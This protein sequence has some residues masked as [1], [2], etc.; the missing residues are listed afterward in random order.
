M[1]YHQLT[2][3]NGLD[4]Y[5][6]SSA[7]QKCIR[8]G[9]E[10]EAMQFAVEFHE[11]GYGDYL[12]KRMRVIASEDIGLADPMACVVVRALYE[13]WKEQHREDKT[14]G[15]TTHRLFVAQAVLYLARAPK[16]RLVD[17]FNI[18]HFRSNE[19]PTIPDFAYDKHT[20]KGKRAGRGIDHFFSEGAKLNNMGDVPREDE[21]EEKA[22]QRLSQP[23]PTDSTP[24]D[25]E[26]Q[27]KLL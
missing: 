3:K 9:L 2:T 27:Q 10:D 14:S 6:V 19:V 13:N 25:K 26:T 15:K 17:H 5:E 16:S 7:F 8:R 21:F 22:R 20:K 1:K 4:F 12:W 23:P 18:W 24:S 11:G